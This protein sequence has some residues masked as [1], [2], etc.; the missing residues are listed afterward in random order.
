MEDN[1]TFSTKVA[2]FDMY[3]FQM[4]H[5]YHGLQGIIAIV[6]SI[7]SLCGY[8]VYGNDVD[9]SYKFILL[10]GG[11]LFT[12][13]IPFTTMHKSMKIIALTPVFRKP[14]NYTLCDEGIKV[15]QEEDEAL[16]PWENVIKVDE[17]LGQLCVYSSP[18]NGYIIP[19]KQ[20]KESYKSLKNYILEHVDKEI[21]TVN[22]K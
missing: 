20:V 8:F 17:K 12:V 4:K 7:A 21:C 22:C 13:I 3:K 11:L 15:S 10:F 6:F 2:V 1:I 14:L 5:A 9:P 18:R 16:L 19:E